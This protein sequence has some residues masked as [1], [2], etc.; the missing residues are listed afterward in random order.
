MPKLL[1][2]GRN[3]YKYTSFSVELLTFSV[4]DNF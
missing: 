3:N 4:G 1:N 2:N